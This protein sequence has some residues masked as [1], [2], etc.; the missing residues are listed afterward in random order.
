[1]TDRLEELRR[2]RA[3]VQQQLE[4]L[5][6][7]IAAEAAA[8]TAPGAAKPA[9]AK[10]Q[11]PIESIELTRHPAPHDSDAILKH[12]GAEAVSADAQT[13]RGCWTVFVLSL[14]ALG[15][16]VVGWYWLRAR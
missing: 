3:L 5:D 13:R 1:M 16:I 6:A 8:R 4:W 15:F 11:S 7:E 2:Q 10:P 14:L 12:Y 9:K